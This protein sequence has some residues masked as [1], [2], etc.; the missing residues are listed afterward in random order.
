VLK[1]LQI[2]HSP[3]KRRKPAA[4]LT[5]GS[6][7]WV[8][9]QAPLKASKWRS[10]E[11][12]ARM[13]GRADLLDK[14]AQLSQPALG[15]SS[16]NGS[17]KEF[18]RKRAKRK[19]FTQ[20]LA[21][22]LAMLES[23]LKK[24]YRNSLH[25][26]SELKQHEDKI[27]AK[28]CKNRWCMVCNSI[29]TAKNINGYEPE[30]KK[31]LDPQFL[32][33]TVPNVK[34]DELRETIRCMKKTWQAVYKKFHRQC[35]KLKIKLVG[36]QKLECTYNAVEDTY[37][38]HFHFIIDGKPIASAI[39]DEW[40]AR[41]PSARRAAQDLRPA[42]LNSMKEMFKY[43]TKVVTTSGNTRRI[44]IPAMDVIFQAMQGFRVFQP[45]GIKAVNDEPDDLEAIT[46]EEKV[47]QLV[48]WKW[49]GNDWH[50]TATG[51]PLTG[52][53]RVT[54]YDELFK[55]AAL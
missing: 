9:R 36:V 53:E 5:P 34:K 24:A 52:F 22:Q 19:Y 17:E 18:L 50:D 45:F 28:Y 44:Y 51:K 55:N 31:L 7:K 46:L 27:T 39:H 3:Y 8:D 14:L 47:D 2:P 32:T 13:T 6:Q 37:H 38:P 1:V 42:D 16:S 30:F 40:L 11:E 25:C 21:G 4:I 43:F 20:Y 26:C 49:T 29:R 35:Q 23:P 33:L 15:A 10:K 48:W 12:F 41:F 54:V